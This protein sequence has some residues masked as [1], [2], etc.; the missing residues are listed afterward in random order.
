MLAT[1]YDLEIVDE[2]GI[3]DW[4]NPPDNRHAFLLEAKQ[5]FDKSQNIEV[6]KQA[7]SFIDWLENA[8]EEEDC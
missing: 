7:K 6:R 5:S 4:R 1:L 3:S 2:G 8:E